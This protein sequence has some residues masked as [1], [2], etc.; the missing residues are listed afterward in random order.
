MPA[1]INFLNSIELTSY[2][3]ILFQLNKFQLEE[4]NKPKVKL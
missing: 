1:A 2:I 3:Q 4:T